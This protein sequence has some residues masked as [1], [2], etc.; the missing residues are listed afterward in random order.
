MLALRRYQ[1]EPYN[2]NAVLFRA[3]N[4]IVEYPDPTFGWKPW[5][6]GDLR[7]FDTEGDHDNLLNEEYIRS[8][9]SEL[10]RLLETA[11]APT[12]QTAAVE[13]AAGVAQ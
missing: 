6:R 8:I 7:I 11:A 13:Q 4:E 9:G 12:Q 3:K 1:P 10:S 2:G 5:I